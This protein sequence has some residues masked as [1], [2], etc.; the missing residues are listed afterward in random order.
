MENVITY[1]FTQ[2]APDS[3]ELEGSQPRAIYPW[4][5]LEQKYITAGESVQ[6]TFSSGVVRSFNQSETTQTR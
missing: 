4:S 1:I 5:L 3:F 6:V 2:I